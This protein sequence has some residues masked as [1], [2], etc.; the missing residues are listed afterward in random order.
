MKKL[1]IP[2]FICVL[3]AV[4]YITAFAATTETRT[5]STYD[6]STDSTSDSLSD[7]ANSGF[8]T[9]GSTFTSIGTVS[10]TNVVNSDSNYFPSDSLVATYNGTLYAKRSDGYY[11]LTNGDV[12]VTDEALIS[13]LDSVSFDYKYTGST[14]ISHVNR[15]P[16]ATLNG[17]TYFIEN[18][19]YYLKTESG[20][21]LVTDEVLLSELEAITFDSSYTFEPVVLKTF[22]TGSLSTVVYTNNPTLFFKYYLGFSVAPA[23]DGEGV[24][25]VHR[26]WWGI[27]VTFISIGAAAIVSPV[28]FIFSKKSKNEEDDAESG[29]VSNYSGFSTS[30]SASELEG[31]YINLSGEDGFDAAASIKKSKRIVH[32]DHFFF[33]HI[34]MVLSATFA[35]IM[36]SFNMPAMIALIITASLSLVFAVLELFQ[37]S[38]W[39]RRIS[40]IAALI[41]AAVCI[42][43]LFYVRHYLVWG[44][45]SS[46][47][48]IAV[49]IALSFIAYLTN[50]K[51]RI[52]LAQAE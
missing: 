5:D 9:A 29:P 36:C 1:L 16:S 35:A 12:L 19:E 20:K 51:S 11:D 52:S 18:G 32:I 3:C 13:Q 50:R 28:L 33:I 37:G 41:A 49:F 4:F 2:V 6:R 14:H 22:Y 47:V 44:I 17:N 30:I 24:N 21:A 10:G 7:S 45:V 38:V 23:G 34:V 26:W 46:L 39:I 40:I 42:F 31:G 25:Y 43:L 48:S 15:L 27:A 8:A